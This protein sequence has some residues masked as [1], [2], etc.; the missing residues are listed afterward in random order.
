MGNSLLE[1]LMSQLEGGGID[2][3]SRQTGVSRDKALQVASAALPALLGGLERNTREPTGAAALAG[4][5]DRDHDGSV[6]D[7]VASFLGQ[8]AGASAGA[9]I[10]KH[11]FGG[12]QGPVE[13][14]VGGMTGVDA[15]SV[16][17]IISMLAP[18]VLGMLG[19][20]KRQ[21][22]LDPGGL[23]DLLGGEKKTVQQRA[24]QAVDLLGSLLDGDGDGNVMDDIAKIGGGLL[25]GLLG[26]KR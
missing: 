18:L 11:V 12:R 16:G 21:Q 14:A 8:G 1:S 4:A 20:T 25:G 23:A 19:R 13:K 10:L 17:Q 3:I 24:P 5:L 22:G 7:D 15:G 9:G 6:L 2:A 26:G